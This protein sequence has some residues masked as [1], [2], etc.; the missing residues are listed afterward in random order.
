MGELFPPLE[1]ECPSYPLGRYDQVS[2]N[3]LTFDSTRLTNVL[4]ANEGANSTYFPTPHMV[5]ATNDARGHCGADERT[6]D[7]RKTEE[8]GIDKH[9]AS[10]C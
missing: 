1:N 4:A 7:L 9:L 6:S 8:F 10:L 5:T 2:S 3:R